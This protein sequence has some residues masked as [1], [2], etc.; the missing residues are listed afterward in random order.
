MPDNTLDKAIAEVK[1]IREFD[2]ENLGKYSP[3]EVKIICH[4]IVNDRNERERNSYDIYVDGFQII[5]TND[6]AFALKNFI[7]RM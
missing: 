6:F 7:D 3:K 2:E 5:R 4:N 1:A